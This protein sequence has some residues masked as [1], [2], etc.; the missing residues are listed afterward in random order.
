[1]SLMAMDVSLNGSM[2]SHNTANSIFEIDDSDILK[3]MDRPRPINVERNRSFD[4]N[5]RMLEHLEYVYSPG[6]R[7][8]FNTPRS[9]SYYEVHAMI[10]DAWEALRR[11]VVRFRGQPVGTI[12]ALDHS[13]EKL[14]Y[15]QVNVP[16][17]VLKLLVSL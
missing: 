17:S 14:N 16:F 1:M 7:S 5:F 9:E 3:L 10:A 11:S 8:G 12:A 13:T 4:E 15:D 6:R 2:R